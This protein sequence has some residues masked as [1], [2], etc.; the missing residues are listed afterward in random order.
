M[1]WPNSIYQLHAPCSRR[2]RESKRERER[3][4]EIEGVRVCGK[5]EGVYLGF[6]RQRVCV[7]GERG[8]CDCV[9]VGLERMCV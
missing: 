8:V 6:E 9:G 3:E 5:R 2:E 7:S 4:R 1:L